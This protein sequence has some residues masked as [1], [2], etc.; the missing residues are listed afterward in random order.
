MTCCFISKKSTDLIYSKWGTCGVEL[1]LSE[2]GNLE[3]YSSMYKGQIIW[4]SNFGGPLHFPEM[5]DLSGRHFDLIKSPNNII[6]V[7]I[8]P[9]TF[10]VIDAKHANAKP[11][12]THRYGAHVH[13]HSS[14]NVEIYKIILKTKKYELRLYDYDVRVIDNDSNEIV[15][16][17]FENNNEDKKLKSCLYEESCTYF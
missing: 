13:L 7:K 14:E 3:F 15:W 10:C 2:D 8:F 4:G 17:C 6:A 11:L 12:W 5:K 16:S 1:R 9:Y